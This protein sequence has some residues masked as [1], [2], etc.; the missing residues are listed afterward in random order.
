VPNGSEP[1][2]DKFRYKLEWHARLGR[3]TV[4]CRPEV[5]EAFARLLALGLVDCFRRTHPEGGHY[6]WWD[7]RQLGFPKNDGLRIDHVLASKALA[8]RCTG[9][10]I[11]REERKGKLPSDHA[12]VVAD[13][14]S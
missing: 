5:R 2:S 13:F 11:D 1:E 4:L 6:S 12:P 3:D 8:A 10:S 9:A 7:Y 14:G